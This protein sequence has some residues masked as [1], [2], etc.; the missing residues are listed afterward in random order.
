MMKKRYKRL[1][2]GENK[3]IFLVGLRGS[4]KTTVGSIVAERLGLPFRDADVELEARAGRSIADIFA[5]DGEAVFR[6]LEE[7]LLIDMIDCGPA[8]IATGGGVVLRETNRSRMKATGTIVWLTADAAM[9]WRR[10]NDDPTSA[11]R[12]PDLSSG[13]LAEIHEMMRLRDPLYRSIADLTIDTMSRSPE[14]IAA[15]ILTVC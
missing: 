10:T 9:L 7:Q 1:R 2:L 6:D 12:R 3:M 4:G 11:G 5:T 15:D 8:V 14:Q 13:G